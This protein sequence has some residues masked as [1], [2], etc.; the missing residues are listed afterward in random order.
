M[1]RLLA[2]LCIALTLLPIQ[3]QEMVEVA[4]YNAT[5]GLQGRLTQLLED[6]NGLLWIA[7]WNGL[8]RF[9]GYEFQQMKPQAGDGCTMTTDRIRNIWL[10]QNDNIYCQTD[11]GIYRFDIRTYQFF[12]LRS[13][14]EQQ[15]AMRLSKIYKGRGEFNG[16][17]IRFVDSE[18][19]DWR[20]VN[21]N[22]VCMA[23][24]RRPMQ[25]LP[26][27]HPSMVRCLTK[28]SKGRIWVANRD[29]QTVRLFNA[30]GSPISY[31]TASG[32]LSQSY[33]PF[34]FSPYSI[35]QASDGSFWLGCKPGGILRLRETG[36]GFKVDLIDS[37]EI[38]YDITEDRQHRLWVG[39]FDHGLA[40]IEQPAAEQP[41]LTF[42]ADDYPNTTFKRVRYIHITPNN[43]MLAATTGG[44]LV[45]QLQKD[46]AKT[47]FNVHRKEPQRENSLSCNATMDIVEMANGRLFVSTETGGINE[48]VSTDLLA[49]SLDFRHY[50]RKNS[51]LPTDMAIAMTR[52]GNQLL[53]VS[54]TQFFLFDPDDGTVRNFDHR[55]FHQVVQF[56][57][58][59]PLQ[60]SA[61]QWLF[62]TNEGAFT[63]NTDEMKRTSYQ[64]PLLLTALTIQNGTPQLDVSDLDTLRLA[65][66]E[67]SF[68]LQFA[69]LDYANPAAISYQFRLGKDTTRWN[70]IGHDH[71]V[72][73]L[74]L[75]PGTYQ[76][77]IRSTNADGQWI[78]NTR[79]LTIIVEPTFWETSLAKL[80]L[81]LTTIA[82][83]GA[84]VYTV[85]YIRRI[86]R[87][88][89]ETLQQYLALLEA[90]KQHAEPDEKAETAEE[91]VPVANEST[92][93]NSSQLPEADDPFMRRLIAFVEE[94][95]GNSD[96]D[97]G[98]MAE[99]CAVS[100]SGL[101]RKVKQ[102]MGITPID[103][104][105][106]ARLKRA[107]QLLS[108][109][110]LPVSDVA[111]R[112]GFSD[113]KYFSRCF[114][115]T[116]GVSP[117]DYKNAQS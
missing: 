85:I 86:N 105:R 16:Q 91:A 89:K 70:N 80:L 113:P 12:D 11:D 45:A 106:E 98:M 22:L 82:V 18:G 47:R 75:E 116:F 3:A 62:A 36:A 104:I 117:S 56:A 21:N 109:G 100:R 93:D 46:A 78:D 58:V 28:D 59:S 88:Q 20:I 102:L 50:D 65:P 76:L 55:F 39:T 111:F 74:D 68:T 14:A 77:A 26:Q 40:C 35:T 25:M 30:D 112:C 7:T 99:A 23:P 83:V 15:E 8:C 41:R 60:L 103:F 44:L 69:A 101:Q 49:P 107:G 6:R 73:L 19:L 29:D 96:A 63:L 92:P 13:K 48:I 90:R 9:D 37:K 97:V 43:V 108:Q 5:N 72:T 64:P 84:V 27:E 24:V 32:R 79:R 53:V 31:L 2:T 94:N 87:R 10:G 61:N 51:L 54:N 67:R 42:L 66:D 34:G 4:R 71:S 95:I 1:K 52:S 17:Y 81:V 57:E 110:S 115:Q 114:K 33:A 38:V